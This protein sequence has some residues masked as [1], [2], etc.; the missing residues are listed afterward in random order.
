LLAAVLIH[1]LVNFA[2]DNN[3]AGETGGDD[4]WHRFGT[5]SGDA[6]WCRATALCAA[7]PLWLRRILDAGSDA[8]AES[9]TPASVP[10]QI[11]K[12]QDCV[13]LTCSQL[14]RFP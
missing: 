7:R 4:G 14:T 8:S 9:P 12:A 2:F 13:A 3:A 6:N 11:M 10:V 1:P 5:S